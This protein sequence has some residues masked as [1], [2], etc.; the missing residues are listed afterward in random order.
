[1]KRLNKFINMINELCFFRKLQNISK[2][3]TISNNVNDAINISF[4]RFYLFQFYR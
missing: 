2:L 4:Y 1:M 3:I